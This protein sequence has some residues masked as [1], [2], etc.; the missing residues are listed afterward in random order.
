M[1]APYQETN[2]LPLSYTTN[3]KYQMPTNLTLHDI[4]GLLTRSVIVVLVQTV[5]K[6]A[7]KIV[8]NLASVDVRES[9]AGDEANESNQQQREVLQISCTKHT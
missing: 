5:L 6:H 7:M 2:V 3:I 8:V 1:T 4:N 9:N